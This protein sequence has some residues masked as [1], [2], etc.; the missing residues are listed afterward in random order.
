[1]WRR[2][3]IFLISAALVAACAS[4]SSRRGAGAVHLDPHNS[5]S[6]TRDWFAAIDAKNQTALLSLMNNANGAEAPWRTK[7]SAARVE[8]SFDEAGGATAV[9]W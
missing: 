8:C 7:P 9:G 3:S 4:A 2:S 5:V 6:T 1:M